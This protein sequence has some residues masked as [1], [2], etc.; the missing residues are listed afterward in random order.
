[1]NAEAN[2]SAAAL[3]LNGERTEFATAPRNRGPCAIA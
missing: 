3:P 2:D 1:M